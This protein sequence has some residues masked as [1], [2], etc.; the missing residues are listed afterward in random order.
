MLKQFIPRRLSY[1]RQQ[2]H[3]IERTM[4]S[5]FKSLDPRPS[6]L[7]S[8]PIQ[9]LVPVGECQFSDSFTP[10]TLLAKYEVSP[11]SFVLRFGLPDGKKSLGL[12]TCACLLAGANIGDETKD[13]EKELVVR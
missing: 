9:S 7:T 5:C 10:V 4:F 1:L 2:Q 3:Q 12:S 8:P 13:G 11:T 6:T